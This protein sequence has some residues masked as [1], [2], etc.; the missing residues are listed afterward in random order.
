MPALLNWVEAIRAQKARWSSWTTGRNQARH[1]KASMSRV[2][3]RRQTDDDAQAGNRR[4]SQDLH[5][6]QRCDG[7]GRKVE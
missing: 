1:P 4:R 3:W 7:A 2:M 5:C 6:R